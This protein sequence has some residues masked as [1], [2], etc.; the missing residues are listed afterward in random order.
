MSVLAA[1]VEGTLVDN[2]VALHQGTLRMHTS[3]V[4]N[5]LYRGKKKR[6]RAFFDNRGKKKAS[7]HTFRKFANARFF[8][9]RVRTR[10][11]GQ[12]TINPIDC[13]CSGDAHTACAFFVNRGGA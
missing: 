10:V 9:K 13:L 2:P 5:T 6:E 12:F 11:L 8:A 1:L 7:A 4:K 3:R